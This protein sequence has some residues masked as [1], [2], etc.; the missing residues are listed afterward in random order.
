MAG[1]GRRWLWAALAV[2]VVALVVGASLIL[3]IGK[4]EPQVEDRFGYLDYRVDGKFLF[5]PFSGIIHVDIFNATEEGYWARITVKGIPGAQSKTQHYTWDEAPAYVKD[6]GSKV[7][8]AT[9]E[10]TWGPK[11]TEMYVLLD[12]GTNYT[13]Y[14]GTDPRVVYR[15]TA[16]GN[17]V[18]VT[19]VLTG[20]D[21]A[22][23]RTGNAA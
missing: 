19:M 1:Q 15:M 9:I 4:E 6:I 2:L 10:T 23:V 11:A 20:T 13:S 22:D 18:E 3:I 5:V 7:G 21:I 16:Q 14:L 8:N 17:G 12:G